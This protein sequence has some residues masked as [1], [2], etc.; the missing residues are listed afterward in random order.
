MALT[1]GDFLSI[2]TTNDASG[3]RAIKATFDSGIDDAANYLTKNDPSGG[4]AI[5]VVNVGAPLGPQFW[6]E[7]YTATT[8]ATS[9]WTATGAAANINAAIVPK[10]T[11]AI[12]ASIPDG[13][14]V[15][16]NTR[17]I[18]AVDL[19]LVRNNAARIASGAYSAIVAGSNNTASGSNSIVLAGNLNSSSGFAAITG[20]ESNTATG[21]FCVSLGEGNNA[22]GLAAISLGRSNNNVGGGGGD[23]GSFAIGFGNY[24]TYTEGGGA[25]GKSNTANNFNAIAIGQSSTASANVSFAIGNTCTASAVGAV[26]IGNSNTAS[27]Q[28]STTIG[29]TN[30]TS[31][32]YGQLSYASGRFAANGDAQAHELIWRRAVTGTAATEL[33]LDGAAARAIL[34]ATN[35]IWSGIVNVSAVCTASGDGTTVVGDI[36]ATEYSV[37]IKRIGTNTTLVAAPQIIGTSIVSDASMSTSLFSITADNTNEALAISFTPPGTAGSTTTFRCLARFSGIQ[38]QY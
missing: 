21:S 2:F 25:L 26:A 5:K 33:F 36:L 7:A 16:G 31:N 14:T 24:C 15:G 23:R 27:G 20:G 11:G 8:Q 3:G 6:T 17:G 38:T 22:T 28:V 34:P 18:Y 4:R 30:A 32:L 12:T 35:S 13:T 10:G 19:Q 1:F 29:G 37:K 9:S